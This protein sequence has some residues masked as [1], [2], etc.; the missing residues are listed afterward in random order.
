MYVYLFANKHHR[1]NEHPWKELL[2]LWLVLSV[3]LENLI[4]EILDLRLFHSIYFK[5]PTVGEAAS[6]Q[7]PSY[8]PCFSIP[9]S[10]V[11][12]VISNYPVEKLTL[13]SLALST[14]DTQLFYDETR[15]RHRC[16]SSSNQGLRMLEFVACT[17][18][19]D[20]FGKEA[21]PTTPRLF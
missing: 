4:L 8:L 12:H 9:S 11:S 19:D 1:N 14:N 5:C 7:S 20:A 16:G 15:R 10:I 3:E 2:V 21:P 6:P 18:G 13:Y 17:F